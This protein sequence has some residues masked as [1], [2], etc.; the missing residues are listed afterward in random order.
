MKIELD[1]KNM[2]NVGEF[3]PERLAKYEE[4]FGVLIEKGCLDGVRGGRASIHF[5]SLGTFMQVSLDYSPWR[6]RKT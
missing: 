5:D 6:R 2:D 3:T 4:I 1:I